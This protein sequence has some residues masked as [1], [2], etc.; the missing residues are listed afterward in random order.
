M[1]MS[2]IS[3]IRM[4]NPVHR[5]E[6]VRRCTAEA[7]LNAPTLLILEQRRVRREVVRALRIHFRAE[8]VA[9]VQFEEGQAWQRE[10]IRTHSGTR[11]SAA[12]LRYNH[13]PLNMTQTRR[14][15]ISTLSVRAELE[16]RKRQNL[17]LTSPA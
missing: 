11:L 5:I 3:E 16:R 6:H 9:A 8:L 2:P 13:Q 14:E 17:Q 10:P 4:L 1:P 12:Y 7:E 15:A